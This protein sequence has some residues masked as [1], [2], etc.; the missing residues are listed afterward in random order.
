MKWVCRS[1]VFLILC[2]VLYGEEPESKKTPAQAGYFQDIWPIIQ[3]QC[4]ACHQP[5][6]K[7]A[8]LQ[9]TDYEGFRQGGKSGPAFV[10]GDP[11]QSLVIAHLT[12][13]REPRM[14]F[15]L[16]PLTDQEIELFRLWIKSGARDDTPPEVRQ[17]AAP[18]GPPVYHLPAVITALAYSPDGNLLAV[19]GYREVLLHK[20]DGSGLEDRLVGISDRIQSLAFSPDGEILMAAGGTPARFGE[21]QFWD[22]ASREMKKSVTV[23]HDTVFGASFSPDASKVAFGCSDQTVRILETATGKELLKMRHHENWVLGTLF[24]MDGKRIVSV[25]RDR[26]AKLTDASSGAFI[27]NINL[28]RGE[29]AAIARHPSRDAVVIGGEDRI[30]YY[31]MMD[32]P[33]K[34]LIADDSTLIREFERQDGEIFA[35]AF[36]PDGKKIAVAG[37]AGQVPIYDIG[38]GNR[39][40]TCRGHEA[41][42]YTVAFHPDGEQL[43][44]GGFDGLVRICEVDSGQLLK[45]FIPVPIEKKVLTSN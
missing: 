15:G 43:A 22:V 29:L 2:S 31:Y 34:M 5:A 44:T 28:L 30:P 45:K 1:L 4:Q 33:R 14:P 37:V 3:R 11:E 41:G 20:S 18:V 13:D 17:P 10:P 36:S 26:A 39:S 40:A 32:R 9:L 27:E 38:T 8:N 25:G 16:P 7:Q 42:I 24:G 12:G 21:V 19:S 23:C 6:V 35:L